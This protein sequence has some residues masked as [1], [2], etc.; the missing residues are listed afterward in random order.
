MVESKQE[1]EVLSDDSS[2]VFKKNIID[3]YI[4]RTISGKFACLKNVCLAQFAYCY[5][6]STSENDYQPE[7]LEEGIQDKGN[8]F[9]I[10]LPKKIVLESSLEV[11]TRRNQRLVLRYYKPK[12]ILHPEKL[13]YHLLVLFYPYANE[14]NLFSTSQTCSGKLLYPMVY[15]AVNENKQIFEPNSELIDT[16]LAE[17]PTQDQEKY[18][19]HDEQ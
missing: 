6:Q 5:R 1:L 18:F 7:I 10:G 3:R 9:A 11:M 4:G 13:V 17:I 8:D 19:D 15:A 2:D 12:K 16:L 14:E